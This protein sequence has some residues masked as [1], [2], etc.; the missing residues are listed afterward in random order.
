MRRTPQPNF[1]QSK[2]TS[3]FTTQSPGDR[4]PEGSTLADANAMDTSA[5]QS[6]TVIHPGLGTGMPSG[7]AVGLETVEKQLITPANIGQTPLTTEFFLKTLQMNTEHI[8]KSFSKNIDDLSK[9]VEAN[10]MMVAEQ[11]KSVLRNEKKINEHGRDL[12]RIMGRLDALE[13]GKLRTS[14]AA[15]RVASLSQEYQAARRSICLWPLAGSNE[16]EIWENAGEF[17]HGPLGVSKNDV[18]PDNLE[19]VARVISPSAGDMVRDEVLVVLKDKRTRDMLMASSVNLSSRVD[20]AGKPSAGTRVEIP[21]ELRDTF[22]LL[23]RFGARLRARHGPGTKRHIK[24]D[25]YCGSLY[26]NVK[27]PGDLTWTKVSPAMAKADLA[28]SIREE[29]DRNQ[30]RFASKLVPGPRERLARPIAVAPPTNTAQPPS[31]LLPPRETSENPDT[32]G[33]RP[34]WRPPGAKGGRM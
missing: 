24:F 14:E 31:S 9:K 20:P 12:S 10:T 23:N 15:P 11:G 21:A 6:S 30:K 27:L 18:G 16:N 4:L 33:Q 25:D 26:A 7:R 2:L 28:A 13:S 34:R 29:E 8:I 5:P 19:S 3:M 17:I 1:T 32:H 22:G